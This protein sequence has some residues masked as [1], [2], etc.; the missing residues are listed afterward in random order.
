MSSL[1]FSTHETFLCCFKLLHC[2]C[3]DAASACT[4]PELLGNSQD[5]PAWSLVGIYTGEVQLS[6]DVEQIFK[7]TEC[8]IGYL[9]YDKREAL[10]HTVDVA[11]SASCALA[12]LAVGWRV[13]A[14]LAAPL[15]Y[16]YGGKLHACMSTSDRAVIVAKCP[17]QT[18]CGDWPYYRYLMLMSCLANHG[19]SV[20]LVCVCSARPHC[21]G[22]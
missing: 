11:L 12:H 1:H 4:A 7:S 21:N 14:L 10:C 6:D 20:T 9:L 18:W 8:G 22:H 16:E 2:C 3:P 5:L 17:L 19:W 13:G 15:D